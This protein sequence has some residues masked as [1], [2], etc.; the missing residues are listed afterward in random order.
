MFHNLC[1]LVFVNEKISYSLV[2]IIFFSAQ[3]KNG[4]EDVDVDYF[5]RKIQNYNENKI[6]WKP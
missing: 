6:I 3:E 5:V 4:H 1:E 2:I